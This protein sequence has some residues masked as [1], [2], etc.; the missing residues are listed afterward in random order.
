MQHAPDGTSYTIYNSQREAADT[1]VFIHGVGLNQQVWQPQI[2]H[3]VATHNIIVYDMLGHGSS[4]RPPETVT[5]AHYV[6]QLANLLD[7]LQSK[8]L[9]CEFLQCKKVTLIG[10]SMGALV[11]VAY[12][13]AHPLDVDKLVPMNIVYGRD[14]DQ[15]AA[16]VARAESVLESGQV[17]GIDTAL[18]RW[19]AGYE[20]AASRTKIDAIRTWLNTVDPLGYG[21]TYYLFATSDDAFTDH[22]HELTM[23]VL[24]LTGEH[25]PNSTPAMSHQMASQTPNGRA[26]VVPN[27]AH[28][29]AYISPEK[30]NAILNDFL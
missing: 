12:S 7:F 8:F 13:L 11:A 17:A 9:Q 22:L 3:F 25:D 24:Y 29:M 6:G 26:V 23:P 14:A 19:F 4:P 27:E 1:L 16:V 10:H 21:R 2:D 18:A 20:D 5:L 30:V 28:M 15:A